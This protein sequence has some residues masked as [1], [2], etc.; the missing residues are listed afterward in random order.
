MARTDSLKVKAK[1]DN[2]G[3]GF[4]QATSNRKKPGPLLAYKPKLKVKSANKPK[5][6][7]AKDRAGNFSPWKTAR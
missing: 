2:S 6:V 3:V 5:F 7:R 4:V 1:D